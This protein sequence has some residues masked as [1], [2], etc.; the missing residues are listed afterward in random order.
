VS[1]RSQVSSL[2]RS[3]DI[4]IGGTRPWDIQVHDE[5]LYKRVV[6]A[7]EACM[8]DSWYADQLGEFFFRLAGARAG[9]GRGIFCTISAT[10]RFLLVQTSH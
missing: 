2:L 6:G 8:D 7:G 5:R 3:A 1:A 4:E 9:A 10:G